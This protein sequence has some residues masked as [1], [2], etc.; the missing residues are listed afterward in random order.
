[1]QLHG[2]GKVRLP[3]AVLVIR[4]GDD[5]DLVQVV[6]KAGEEPVQNNT[7]NIWEMQENVSLGIC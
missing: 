7:I 2:L 3:I 5:R 6:L 4:R 1:M